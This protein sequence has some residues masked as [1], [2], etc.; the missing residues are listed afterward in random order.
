MVRGVGKEG[1]LGGVGVVNK[2]FVVLG[3][4]GGA[5]RGVLYEVLIT[6]IYNKKGLQDGLTPPKS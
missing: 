6:T 2:K 3:L 5:G 1:A 4:G